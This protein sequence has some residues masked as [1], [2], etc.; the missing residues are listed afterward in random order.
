VFQHLAIAAVPSYS[1]PF[2]KSEAQGIQMMR[3]DLVA[4]LA[5]IAVPL[6]VIIRANIEYRRHRKELSPEERK[7]LDEI[8]SFEGQIW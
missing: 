7:R 5:V 3:I 8:S 2:V 1:L 6:I 4:L